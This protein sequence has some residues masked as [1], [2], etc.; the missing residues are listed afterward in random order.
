MTEIFQFQHG[1][2]ERQCS[3]VL[4]R[5][6]YDF[7]S[8][9]VRLREASSLQQCSSEINFNSNM[10]RLRDSQAILPFGN[11]LHF[12]SNMV[13]LRG[14]NRLSLS[15]G[16]QAFQFQHGTIESF[17]FSTQQWNVLISIPTWYD[18]ESKCGPEPNHRR[19]HFNSNM[20]RL[21]GGVGYNDATKLF[22]FNSNMVR[23]RVH[24]VFLRSQLTS[25]FNSNMVRL[26]AGVGD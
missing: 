3:T 2:I 22:Y 6:D 25:H 12:N 5:P 4:R 15:E 16:S 21:R 13:R 24:A 19:A 17:E 11:A 8:N 1:T 23:L 18:W 14:H 9:M 20:V 10:V 26:R 7:N